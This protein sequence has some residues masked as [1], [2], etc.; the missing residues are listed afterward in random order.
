V[1]EEPLGRHE[2]AVF[3]VAAVAMAVTRLMALARS[4]WDWDEFDFM[5]A[6][7]TYDVGLRLA[8]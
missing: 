5:L 4:P 1:T 3:W 7:Q 2:R 8:A 6:L